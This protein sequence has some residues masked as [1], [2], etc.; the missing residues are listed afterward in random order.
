MRVTFRP[1]S[2]SLN[3]FG[4]RVAL[5]FCI[6]SYSAC[7]ASMFAHFR[8]W[9]SATA[10]RILASSASAAVRGR[11]GFA[12]PMCR[13]NV[14]SAPAAASIDLCVSLA[15][16]AASMSLAYPAVPRGSV[17]V[18]TV[19]MSFISSANACKTLLDTPRSFP[20]PEY[21]PGWAVTRRE[22]I[23]MSSSRRAG[24]GG[25]ALKSQQ[26]A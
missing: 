5:S 1:N 26:Q 19:L 14:L 12:V 15:F 6:L 25:D 3:R 9:A 21:P 10:S 17:T 2:I 7:F 4:G 16:C 24:D 18:L 8:R 23:A 11:F 22:S 13:R 20:V